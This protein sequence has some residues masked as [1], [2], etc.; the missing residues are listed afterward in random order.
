M[1][2]VDA[3]RQIAAIDPSAAPRV[4]LQVIDLYRTSKDLSNARA[5]ADAALKIYPKDAKI[6]EEHASVVADQGK[7]D[8]AVAEM[9][10]FAKD[11]PNTEGLVQIAQFYEKAKRY[12]DMAKA[13]DEGEKLAASDGDKILVYYSRGAMFDRQKKYDASEAEFRKVLALN[14]D[15][16]GA[17]NYLGYS[18]A[19]RNVRLDEAYQMVKKALDLEPD[20]YAYMDSL[21]WVYYRQGKL[22]DAEQFLVRALEGTKD[23]T[24]H[25]HL[26]DIYFKEGKTR[27]A[28]TQWQASLKEYNAGNQDDVDPADMAKVTQKLQSAQAQLAKHQ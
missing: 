18:L 15:N 17:L 13:L 22:D 26:G 12:D 7:I 6:A 5:E 27:E 10:T 23:P 16:A 25:D 24:V 3:L 9:R 4:E 1:P 20:Q 8:E 14:P 28:V 19:D 2:A 21:G 11:K